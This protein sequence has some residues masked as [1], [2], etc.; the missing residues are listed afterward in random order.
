MLKWKIN[1]FTIAACLLFT[2]LA[3]GQVI[4]ID[5]HLLEISLQKEHF[6]KREVKKIE[7]SRFN[8]LAM[9]MVG[10]MWFYQKVVSA[11]LSAGC[12]YH[13]SCSNFSR[14]CIE[15]YG[16]FK[17]IALSADRLSRCSRLSAAEILP[18]AE[19]KDG[20]VLDLPSSYKKPADK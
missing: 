16:W 19:K 3:K 5:A 2:F 15:M 7:R 20:R 17:G 18:T 11:Q 6:H 12:L 13:P 9:P 1:I 8:P 4:T 10:A 14:E